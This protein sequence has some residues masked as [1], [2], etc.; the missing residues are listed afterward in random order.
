MASGS[1]ELLYGATLGMLAAVNPCGFP[2]LPAYLE[3]F[4]G[5]RDGV[6]VAGRVARALGAG[7]A[8]TVGFLVL[9]VTV[10]A[11]VDAGWA[12]VASTTYL[13]ARWVMVALGAAMVI[14]GVAALAGRPLRLPLPQ[15]GSGV[16]LRRPVAMVVFGFS[17]GVAS[18]GCAL[19]LFVSGVA[20]SFDRADPVR[21][22]ELFVAYALGMGSVLC[23]LAVVVAVAGPAA[24]RP[25]RRSSRLV[26]PAGAALLVA[27]GVYLVVDWATAIADPTGSNPVTRA[28]GRAQAWVAA[29]L[30]AHAALAIGVLAGAVI[31]GILAVGAAGLRRP[32]PD[33]GSVAA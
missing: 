2:M 6:P 23:A 11:L 24:T 7:A 14:T 29:L 19:P 1:P 18:L 32:A 26:G 3:L 20:T 30:S 8:A 22:G 16:G 5:H 17:Y 21:G 33:R 28:V 9:F 10:G 31:A 25:L 15:P 12:G 27:V 13:A 4:T